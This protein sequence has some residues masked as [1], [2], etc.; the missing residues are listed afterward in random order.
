MTIL[1]TRPAAAATLAALALA[2]AP[3]VAAAHPSVFFVTPKK[4]AGTPTGSLLADDAVQYAISQHGHTRVLKETNGLTTH[5]I[6]DYKLLPGAWRNFAGRT[7]AEVLAQGDTGGQPHAIC[8][9]PKLDEAAVLAWQGADPFYNYVPWQGTSVGLDD[10]GELAAWIG[11][12]KSKTGFDLATLP[13]DPTAA[14]TAAKAACENPAIGNGTYYAADATQ[15]AGSAFASADIAAAVDPLNLQIASL[16]DLAAQRAT[17]LSQ[18]T[19]AST[20]AATANAAPLKVSIASTALTPAAIAKDGLSVKVTGVPLDAVTVTVKLSAARA[21]K[22]RLP[23]RTIGSASRH[24]DGTGAATFVVTLRPTA[25]KKLATA[26]GSL[27]LS[28]A[29]QLAASATTT[30]TLKG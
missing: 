19:A 10:E 30:T 8:L 11:V 7:K 1:P 18:A 22:L 23:S 13:A 29:A 17:A 24:L 20:A 14:A 16:T 26:K 4:A 27:P 2:A 5:G 15:T 6:L 25:A 9:S 12:I 21:A 3:S 28:V